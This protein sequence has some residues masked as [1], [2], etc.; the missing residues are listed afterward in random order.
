ANE[1]ATQFRLTVDPPPAGTARFINPSGMTIPPEG[2][3]DLYPSQIH[4]SGMNGSVTKLVLSIDK[5]SHARVQDVNMLLVS[6]Q[7]QSVI[8]FSHV[9]GSRSD[10]NVRVN[11]TDSSTYF[12]PSNFSL[13]SEPLKPAVFP[14]TPTFPAP[15]PSGPYGP[16]ALSTF[17]GGLANGTWSLYVFDD[18]APNGGSIVGGWSLLVSASG[19][20]SPPAISDI[21]DQSTPA[22]TPTPA[23][24]FG[25]SD[26]DTPVED[27]TVTAESSNTALV[28]A[29]NI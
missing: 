7:G 20:G 6:P 23:I 2:V 25:V 15:A 24:P 17:N 28:P 3:A 8:I 10:S 21:P 19:V 9:S 18:S 12:L 1:A 13:W 29:G 16:V 22:N 11:L 14:P 5:F 26:V 4:V 27:L